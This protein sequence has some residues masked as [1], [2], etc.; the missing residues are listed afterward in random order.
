[1]NGQ[2]FVFG[3]VSAERFAP[4][5]V[6]VEPLDAERVLLLAGIEPG[7]RVVTIGAELLDQ[8]R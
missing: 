7:K 3:H 1:V 6:R 8:V 2:T 5:A 4:R